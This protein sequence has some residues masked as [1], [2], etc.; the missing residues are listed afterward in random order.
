MNLKV[1]LKYKDVCL[2][3]DDTEISCTTEDDGRPMVT[4]SWDDRIFWT[5]DPDKIIRVTKV[6]ALESIILPHAACDRHPILVFEP[7]HKN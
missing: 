6:Q 3:L 5:S 7:L 4:N 1:F 2:I